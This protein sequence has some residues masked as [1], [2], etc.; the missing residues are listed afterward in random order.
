MLSVC[1]PVYRYD[2]RPLVTE[3]LRQADELTET[4][5]VLV[6]DDASPDNGDWGREELRQTSGIRYVELPKNIGRAA[7]RNLMAREAAQAHLVMMDADGEILGDYLGRWVDEIIDANCGS[8]LFLGIGGRRYDSTP[9]ADH[10]YHLHWWYGSEREQ[11]SLQRREREGWLGFQSNNFLASRRLL[12][13]HPLPE[14]LLGYGH[15]DTLW[16]QQFI[17][18]EVKLLQVH[19]PVIHL[20]L[21][22]NDVFLEKQKQAITNLC[23][24][25]SSHP[26][27]RTR[28]ID[29]TKR[30]PFLPALASP[31][32]ERWLTSY[33]SGRQKPSL[34]ALD[35]LKLR[36]WHKSV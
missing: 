31:I 4:V 34:Y 22:T 16:G 23:L 32:P 9:P 7:I 12:I 13:D 11:R 30:F 3:L 26:H 1:I 20:G 29:L 19:N 6:Y 18:S 8:A 36:W 5:E 15:E 21:E 25:K 2:V 14:A 33:L 35:L 17:G 28:L 10:E 24:L 27:L